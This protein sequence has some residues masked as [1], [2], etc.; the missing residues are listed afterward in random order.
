MYHLPQYRKWVLQ[1]EIWWSPDNTDKDVPDVPLQA[2]IQSRSVLW[3][4]LQFTILSLSSSF[5]W[6][7]VPIIAHSLRSEIAEK[8]FHSGYSNFL[9]LSL[10]LSLSLSLYI[11][12]F[13]TESSASFLTWFYPATLK[14]P[15]ATQDVLRS[16]EPLNRLQ[17]I[18]LNG[19]NFSETPFVTGFFDNCRICEEICVIYQIS[20][21]VIFLS[22]E[23]SICT[24]EIMEGKIQKV[25]LIIL[26]ITIILIT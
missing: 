25:S 6:R 5:S 11:Y 23:R 18:R 4:T 3:C 22:C 14:A 1:E 19:F 2:E 8:I 13:S 12:L 10:S 16:S 26:R 9:F 20:A 7:C 17:S 21:E 15:A 24:V